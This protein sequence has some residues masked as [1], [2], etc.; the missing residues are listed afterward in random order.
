MN[1]SAPLNIPE[2]TNSF[3]P[4][5][6]IKFPKG[7]TCNDLKRLPNWNK[8]SKQ[9]Q[10]FLMMGFPKRHKRASIKQIAQEWDISKSS[11]AT[12]LGRWIEKG[13][14]KKDH[15]YIKD[16]NIHS[17]NY[18][19][20]DKEGEAHMQAVL[21]FLFEGY[22]SQKTRNNLNQRVLKLFLRRIQESNTNVLKNKPRG[23][24]P[25]PSSLSLEKRKISQILDQESIGS[26]ITLVRKALNLTPPDPTPPKKPSSEDI[27]E[28]KKRT[29]D[30]QNSLDAIKN[31]K[32][33]RAIQKIFNKFDFLKQLDSAYKG[34]IF[35]LLTFSLDAIEKLL[36]LMRK[37]LSKK[38]RLRSFWGFFMHEIQKAPVKKRFAKTWFPFLAGEYRDAADGKQSKLMDGVDSGVIVQSISKLERETQEIIPENLLE[39]LVRHKTQKL[40][41]A[42]DS[43]CYR[44]SLGKAELPRDKTADDEDSN[45]QKAQPI[46][47][48]VK[49]NLHTKKP[50]T[51]E[52]RQKGAPSSIMRKII[53]YRKPEAPKNFPEET[54]RNK[55][56]FTPIKSWIGMSFYALKLGSPLAITQAF[57]QKRGALA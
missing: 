24:L 31:G 35:K 32:K 40:K 9:D 52:D 25:T 10:R 6:T 37:K 41:A 26:V 30:N 15:R 11:T 7:I 55:K 57:C 17:A 39:R 44:M 5:G 21:S 48:M 23:D 19:T 56:K 36:K 54:P 51:E 50:Y 16:T 14:I 1:S 53:G 18:Y 29:Y 2:Y 42:L 27:H 45:H 43:I 13:W 4:P 38:W 33:F 20:V 8:L 46:Y 34:T 49:I 22:E 3:K 47:E 12:T 28:P